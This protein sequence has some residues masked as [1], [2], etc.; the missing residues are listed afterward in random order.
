MGER[1]KSMK[2]FE[3]E[4]ESIRSVPY[5]VRVLS[6]GTDAERER[7]GEEIREVTTGYSVFV[8]NESG[9]TEE[10][11]FYPVETNMGDFTN[12]EEEV[13]EKIKADFAPEKGYQ[14]NE[15]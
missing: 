2:Y 7:E 6:D 11:E 10:V 4:R 9:I 14:N 15:W 3:V 1:F 8:Y 12:N 5:V 13:L